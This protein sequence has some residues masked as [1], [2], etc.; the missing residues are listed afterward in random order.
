MTFKKNFLYLVLIANFFTLTAFASEKNDIYEGKSVINNSL[1]SEED[2]ELDIDLLTREFDEA[3]ESIDKSL[4]VLDKNQDELTQIHKE[5][6]EIIERMGLNNLSSSDST[7]FSNPTSELSNEKVI[8]I[9]NNNF[10]FFPQPHSSQN[11]R[12]F[13]ESFKEKRKC[14]S[15]F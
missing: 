9:I 13:K 10:N 8:Q 11:E 2:E 1:I 6:K 3:S 5:L 7:S 4:D 12:K 15:F 14:C